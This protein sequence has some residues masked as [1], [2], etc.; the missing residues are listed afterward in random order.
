MTFLCVG[1]LKT[2]HARVAVRTVKCHPK[3]N[4]RWVLSCTL[5]RSVSHQL[6][7]RFVFRPVR[8]NASCLNAAVLLF[9]Y[10]VL[11]VIDRRV[12]ATAY[13][14]VLRVP[15]A[16]TETTLKS[17][18]PTVTGMLAVRKMRYFGCETQWVSVQT[19]DCSKQSVQ[20]QRTRA[21]NFI[22]CL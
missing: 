6:Y 8:L 1:I 17:G 18:I 4:L 2:I 13:M 5:G 14:R 15:C 7:V 11:C 19:V 16:A 3:F 10:F 9:I 20:R 21:I 12:E 22:K